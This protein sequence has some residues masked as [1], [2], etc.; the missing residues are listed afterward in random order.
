MATKRLASWLDDDEHGPLPAVLLLL[1]VV[2]GLVQGRLVSQR[3]HRR[4]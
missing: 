1:T 2:T 4:T 3:R